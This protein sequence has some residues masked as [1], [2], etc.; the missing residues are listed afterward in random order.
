ME[1]FNAIL[2][3]G[4][5]IG[6]DATYNYMRKRG[7]MQACKNGYYQAQ[8]E[9]T[10][11]REAYDNGKRRERV[12]HMMCDSYAPYAPKHVDGESASNTFNIPESFVDHMHNN[13]RAVARI[14]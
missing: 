13:G 6:I 7:E 2:L 14:K 5:G 11:R 12:R 3:I 1:V 10:I 9:E 4:V 8:K